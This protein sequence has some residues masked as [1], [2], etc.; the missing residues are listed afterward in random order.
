[1]AAALSDHFR[2]MPPHSIYVW[3]AA[4]AL[5]QC[6][7]RT[8]SSAKSGADV[9]SM[10]T[11]PAARATYIAAAVRA[12]AAISSSG[13]L[14]MLD[15]DGL[16]L[17]RAWTTYEAWT[18]LSAHGPGALHVLHAQV[19]RGAPPLAFGGPRPASGRPAGALR[20]CALH[21]PAA[22]AQ[23]PQACSPRSSRGCGS[24]SHPTGR[25]PPALP[26]LQPALR[27]GAVQLE[28]TCLGRRMATHTWRTAAHTWR[29]A[30]HTW[31]TLT[32]V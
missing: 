19:R 24:A 20:P 2:G 29:T 13:A 26:P 15:R 31:R 25:G 1:M 16:A 12:A 4:L 7:P 32:G 5:P 21:S 30:A 23:P 10:P 11:D 17:K 8:K 22:Q 9:L 3:L 28:C 6:P 14:L 27:N 18:V